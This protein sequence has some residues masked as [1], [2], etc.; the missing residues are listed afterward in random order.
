MAS[1]IR[2]RPRRYSILAAITIVLVAVFLA[3]RPTGHALAT[4][5]GS[6]YTVT[7]VTDT[8]PDPNIV[9]TTLIA[10]EANVDIGN[11]VTAHARDVQRRRSPARPSVSR[12]ATR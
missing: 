8:N 2:K 1:Q 10:E 7:D 3:A 12:W 4:S 6:P 11:G 5:D 9:E